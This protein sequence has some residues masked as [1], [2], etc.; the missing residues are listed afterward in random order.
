MR[1][2]QARR[3]QRRYRRVRAGDRD[4]A[5]PRR[6]HRLHQQCP[7]IADGGGARI[8][9]EGH[10]L[11]GLEQRDDF[12]RGSAFVMLVHRHQPVRADAVMRQQMRGVARVLRRDH[13]RRRQHIQRAQG[14]VTQITNRRGNYI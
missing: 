12:F 8:A 10:A 9:D 3:R 4:D 1:V 6:P 11:S 14:D 7:R 2:R 13:V 5:Q